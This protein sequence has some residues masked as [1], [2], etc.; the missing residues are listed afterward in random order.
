MNRKKRKKYSVRCCLFRGNSVSRRPENPFE[1][2]P[3]ERACCANREPSSGC[4][5]C[6]LRCPPTP[7]LARRDIP[8]EPKVGTLTP[9]PSRHSTR[10]RRMERQRRRRSE[11]GDPRRPRATC[12]RSGRAAPDCASF[13]EAPRRRLPLVDE[14]T[15]I[16]GPNPVSHPP[17]EPLFDFHKKAVEAGAHGGRG[18]H[19]HVEL[20]GRQ[21]ISN[22]FS[23]QE[24]R[25]GRMSVKAHRT[26]GAQTT[27]P[28]SS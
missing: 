19:V 9:G 1:G 23:A 15:R 26:T 13:A 20:S 25:D 21:H 28:R 16:A 17:H 18:R 24:P 10:R 8:D 2:P 5:V 14:T 6:A 4:A 3:G 12:S 7:G 22:P 27:E 11:E